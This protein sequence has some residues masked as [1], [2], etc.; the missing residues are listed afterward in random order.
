MRPTVLPGLLLIGLIGLASAD[1]SVPK[2]SPKEALQAFQDLIGTWRG[3]GEPQQGT[4]EE[5]QKGFWTESINWAWQ[6]KGDDTF[7]KAVFEKSKHY[8][9][10]ELRYL[11]S[12]EHYRLLLQTTG[13]ES[14]TFEGQ[15]KNNRL[16]LERTDEGRKETQRLTINLLHANRYLFRYEVK[17]ADQAV[18]TIVYQVG[19]T[20]EG[21]AFAG[22]DGK[23]EC[24]VSGGLG[25]MPVVYKGKTYYVCCTGCR[26]AFKDEPEKYIK[27]FE[28]R[29]NK[30]D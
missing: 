11:P 27:E 8:T 28:A 23:P 6:F 12:T 21:V 29:K 19:A 25:T 1:E 18:F 5:K 14:V 13:K 17:P 4:R 2:K 30:K 15:K 20:K 16:I 22:G 26:D 24:V 3:T 9:S 10:A 7:L